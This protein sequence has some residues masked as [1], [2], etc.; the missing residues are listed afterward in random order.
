MANIKSQIKRNKQAEAARERNKAVKSALK[1]TIKR[2]NEAAL[3]GVE[4]AGSRLKEAIVALD[5]AASDKVIHANEAAR[6]KS[7]MTKNYNALVANPPAPV[8]EAEK[9]K[10]TKKPAKAATAAKAAKKP[11]AKKPVEKKSIIKKVT[12]KKPAAKKAK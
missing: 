8:V 12:A 11:A 10:K 1:T 5:R 3:V 2:F 9:P 7:T 4:E 6:K